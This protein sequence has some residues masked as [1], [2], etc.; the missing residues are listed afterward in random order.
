MGVISWDLGFLL[1]KNIYDINE[2][3]NKKMQFTNVQRIL[4]KID[5]DLYQNFTCNMSHDEFKKNL[6]RSS[7]KLKDH[8]KTKI[9]AAFGVAFN[10]KI[11]RRD[12]KRFRKFKSYPIESESSDLD[13][14][15]KYW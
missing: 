10:R 11:H 1:H 7:R 8:F 9:G 4:S 6:G 13:N 5:P 12:A 14:S 3:L 15:G 2:N